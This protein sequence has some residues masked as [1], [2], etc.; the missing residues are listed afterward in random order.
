MAP[1]VPVRENR[2]TLRSLLY[3]NF[4]K[5][6]GEGVEEFSFR[7]LNDLKFGGVS[8]GLFKIVDSWQ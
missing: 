2:G 7:I 6:S 4:S 1:A 8:T 5:T 3:A